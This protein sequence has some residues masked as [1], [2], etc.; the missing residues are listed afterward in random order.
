MKKLLRSRLR[1]VPSLLVFIRFIIRT[2]GKLRGAL[3]RDT[4]APALN[5]PGKVH[6]SSA[7]WFC[8]YYDHTPFNPRDE[9]N[10]LIHA[11]THPAWKKPSPQVAVSILLYNW[12]TEE[13]LG[14]LGETYSWNWQQGARAMWLDSETAIYN[15]YDYLEGCYRARVVSK[16]GV[17]KRDLP[18]PVQ[19]LDSQGRIYSLSYEALAAIR[20]DYG[21]RNHS[22]NSNNRLENK[23]EQYNIA[24]N[25]RVTLVTL[26]E[27]KERTEKY[28]KKP[29]LRSKFNHIMVS[30]DSSSLVFLFRYVVL[31]CRVTDMYVAPTG[32]GAPTL[33]VGD[34]GVSHVCWLDDKTLV[35][36]MSGVE[37]FGYYRI[38]VDVS[39][40]PAILWQYGDGH[41]SR[42]GRYNLLTDTYPD[43]TTRRHMF[44]YSLTTQKAAWLASFPEPL[45]LH[46]ETRC[47]LHPSASGSGKYIQADCTTGHRRTIAVLRCS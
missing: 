24:T 43:C 5:L 11:T 13:V 27:M 21:Y 39:K 35:A 32:G 15:I 17:F 18:I 7:N 26:T 4:F 2:A 1:R 16:D 42:L 28:Y 41:P 33:L 25:T 23:I 14:S 45:L 40:N 44:N 19:E 37:G 38:P 30:P 9:T 3:R 10:L 34:A 36:T 31:G 20:P 29:I 47:D 8:G 12:K 22:S 6:V 46:G